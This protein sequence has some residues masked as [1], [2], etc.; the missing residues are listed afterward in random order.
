M[1]DSLRKSKFV[2]AEWK[3]VGL[4]GS[5][6]RRGEGSP[7]TVTR[8]V[9][10]SAGTDQATRPIPVAT[11]PPAAAL[12]RDAEATLRQAPGADPAKRAGSSPRGSPVP[13]E[14]PRPGS[15][16]APSS[17]VPG[18]SRSAPGAPGARTAGAVAFPPPAVRGARASVPRFSAT[19]A[20]RNC[21]VLLGL[22][23]AAL[24][25]DAFSY[26]TGSLAER[27]RHPLHVWLKPSGAIGQGLGILAAVLFFFLMLYPLRKKFATGL[28]FTGKVGDWLDWHVAAGFMVPLLAATHA[29]WRFKGLIGLG[30]AAMALVC[31]S[32]I[33]GRYLYSHIPRR[34]DGLALS[35]EEIAAERTR[36]LFEFTAMTGVRPEFIRERLGQEVA[37]HR[38]RGLFGTLRRMLADDRARR[39]AVHEIRLELARRG[40]RNQ[41][42]E[43]STLRRA[44]ALARREMALAQQERLLDGTHRIFRFWH[45]AHRPLAATALLAVLAHIIVAVIFGATWFY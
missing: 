1:S 45:V 11:A 27:V 38:G 39:R 12:V 15:R 33:V 3:E 32:G 17:A 37:S 4:R 30:Y 10:A 36:L 28:S 29:G 14:V 20:F 2:P 44:I 43:H 26:Y 19:A 5:P 41:R 34:R 9:T 6:V 23:L 24:N 21:L 8:P 25:I 42:S 7:G 35:R 18:A 40:Q 16:P 31:L 13:P 22:I